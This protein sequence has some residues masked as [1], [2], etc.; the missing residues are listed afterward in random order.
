[1]ILLFGDKA[2]KTHSSHKNGNVRN[3][4]VENSGI[5][6]NKST[7]TISLL[8]ANEYD[9]YMFSQQADID[10]SQYTDD[11]GYYLSSIGF[12]SEY[13]EA[14]SSM[15]SDSSISSFGG[16]CGGASYSCSCSSGSFSS[17]C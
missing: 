17:V 15:G 11:G 5:L 2:N 12:M 16:D 14:I 3:N 9:I 10:Y 4:P 7:G 8:D 13:S 6:A 1:M